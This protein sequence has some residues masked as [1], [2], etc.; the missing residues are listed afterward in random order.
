MKPT[1]VRN[2]Q[3]FQAA[4][5]TRSKQLG[6]TLSKELRKKYGRRSARVI[7]GDTVRVMRGEFKGIDGKVTHVS[8]EKNSIAV[9]GIKR[10]KLKGGNVD[11]YIHTSNVMITGVNL[12]DKWRQNRMEKQKTKISKE[13]PVETPKEKPQEK[14]LKTMEPPKVKSTKTTKSTKEKPKSTKKETKQTK[15]AKPVKK[16]N[17]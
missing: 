13:K 14:P 4:H 9:E 12:D 3:I 11:I 5:H 6:A 2:R 10:E 1:I 15:A 16:E 7:E 8:T 17:K